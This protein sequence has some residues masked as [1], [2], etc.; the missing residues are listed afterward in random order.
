MTEPKIFLRRAQLTRIRSDVQYQW[1]DDVFGSGG[2][3]VSPK[4]LAHDHRR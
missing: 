4:G 1:F 3:R 2:G